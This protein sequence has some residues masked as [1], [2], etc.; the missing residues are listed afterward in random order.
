MLAVEWAMAE[1]LRNSSL[2]KKVRAEI[3]RVVGINR[4]VEESDI[5]QLKY[6]Q[7]IVKETLR[8]IH[9]FLC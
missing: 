9:Q 1:V 5:P 2:V 4:I 7:A 6:I 8:C 3:K